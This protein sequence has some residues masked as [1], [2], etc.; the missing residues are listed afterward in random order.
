MV[1]EWPRRQAA[2]RSALK[3]ARPLEDKILASI[4]KRVSHIEEMLTPAAENSSVSRNVTKEAEETAHAV[5]KV[6][7]MG[8]CGRSV[9]RYRL[10]HV[11]DFFSPGSGS[12]VCRSPK[13]S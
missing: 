8:I 5:A 6:R 12:S 10:L 13:T 3:K 9:Y 1:S 7:I 4:E 2:T 11:L